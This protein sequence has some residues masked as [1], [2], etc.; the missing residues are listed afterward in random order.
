MFSVNPGAIL[1]LI[2][3]TV[4]IQKSEGKKEWKVL[5]DCLKHLP[6]GLPLSHQAFPLGYVPRESLINLGNSLGFFFQR[7]PTAFSLFVPK[8]EQEDASR[9]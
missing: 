1:G 9:Q 4:L 6:T 2:I 3:F 8:Y 7:A 5:R